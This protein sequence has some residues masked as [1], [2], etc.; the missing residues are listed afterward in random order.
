MRT[1]LDLPEE[2]VGAARQALGFKSRT[3]TMIDALHSG[4]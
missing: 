1:T 2:L 3:D 4:L